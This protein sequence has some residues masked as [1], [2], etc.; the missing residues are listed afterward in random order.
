MVP[1]RHPSPENVTEKLRTA[2]SSG[3]S[4]PFAIASSASSSGVSGG[5]S[6]SGTP[7]AGIADLAVRRVRRVF[8]DIDQVLID[9][10]WRRDGDRHG[11]GR[12][13][14]G[15]RRSG[16]GGDHGGV[17]LGLRGGRRRRGR[18]WCGRTRG[19]GG[20]AAVLHDGARVR[21]DAPRAELQSDG[22]CGPPDAHG[23]RVDGRGLR[24]RRRTGR[25]GDG[26]DGLG[27]GG[28]QNTRGGEQRGGL[29]RA[30]G[31]KAGA[32][33]TCPETGDRAV[34]G[35]PRRQRPRRECRR[36]S[37]DRRSR[38]MDEHL[39][40]AFADAHLAPDVAVAAAL[41]A[42]GEQ[43]CPLLGGER[44]DLTECGPDRLA[45][46]DLVL[47]VHALR[48]RAFEQR[49]IGGAGALHRVDRPV[50]DDAIEPGSEVA[51]LAAVLELPPDAEH[52]RLDDVLS[53]R[54]AQH[55]AR[56]R[57]QR[58]AVA[59]D[60]RLERTLASCRGETCQTLIGLGAQQCCGQL[61]T[62]KGSPVG[63]P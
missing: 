32:R 36:R 57:E 58:A 2:S 23:R 60:D 1:L 63:Q 10:G 7:S 29:E 17:P 4:G 44:R 33:A 20:R 53:P 24:V 8:R 37:A 30:P 11:G 55:P 6:E 21:P 12:L 45:M 52:R 25:V 9:G 61:R 43:R 14:R 48:L 18:G 28:S 40:G 34:S 42:D 47:Q 5:I 31:D 26:M 15:G 35:D 54:V 56:V 19:G 49:Q 27:P 50:V 59:L 16:R 3:L 46:L 41:D 13:G 22:R 51:D 38:A 39:H 62:H